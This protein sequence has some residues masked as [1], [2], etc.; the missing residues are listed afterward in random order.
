MHLEPYLNVWIFCG[1]SDHQNQQGLILRGILESV[2]CYLLPEFLSWNSWKV[3]HYPLFTGFTS[4]V[5]AISLL[6]IIAI[7][8]AWPLILTGHWSREKA[9]PA[10]ILQVIMWYLL[11]PGH[12][13]WW[14]NGV[15]GHLRQIAET[16][17]KGYS[18]TTVQSK[19]KNSKI[20]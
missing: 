4:P 5:K 16:K 17:E 18:P 13:V 8:W 19:E 11:G 10:M 9:E 6:Q 2:W 12:N 1:F 7:L 20:C 14:R 3:V 15:F